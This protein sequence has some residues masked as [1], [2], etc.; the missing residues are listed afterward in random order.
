MSELRTRILAKKKALE[1]K[2]L[3]K[4]ADAEGLGEEATKAINDRLKLLEDCLDG[5]WD[6]LESKWSDV[7][8]GVKEK[9]NVWLGKGE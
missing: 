8:E 9:L 4:T 7:S 2:L 5:S 6:K 1:A 3:E